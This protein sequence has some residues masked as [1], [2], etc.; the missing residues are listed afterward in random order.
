MSPAVNALARAATLAAMALAAAGLMRLFANGETSQSAP[1]QPPAEAAEASPAPLMAAAEI[2]YAPSY[3]ALNPYA[4]AFAQVT[5]SAFDPADEY[6][7]LPRTGG[8][9]TVASYCSACHSLQIVMAQHQSRD[10]WDY[11]L[12]WMVESQGMAPPAP[13]TRDEI[14]DYLAREFGA[15]G[16]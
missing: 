15:G 8:Y 5:A 4:D 6:W 2:N 12:A 9:E 14:L 3:N 13:Q 11:L 10:G 1:L 7:G 16:P